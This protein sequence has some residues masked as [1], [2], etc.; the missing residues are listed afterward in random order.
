MNTKTYKNTLLIVFFALASCTTSFGQQSNKG[1]KQ[2]EISQIQNLLNSKNYEFIA[3]T[4]LPV[5]GR[6][7]NLTSAYDVQVLGYTVISDLPYFGRAFVA[8]IDPSDGGIHFTSNE[9]GY[10]LKERKKGGWDIA[11]LP[12][13][14]KDIRQMLLNVT[15]SGY[16]TLQVISNDRQQ[17][18]FNGYIRER[19]GKI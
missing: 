7:I 1:K 8:P 18:S 13:D 14:A 10:S 11:I 4:A 12:K 2:N 5:G 17:I 3:Q 15:E 16:G 9:F 6:A 19:K